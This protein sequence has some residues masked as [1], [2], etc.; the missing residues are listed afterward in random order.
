MGFSNRQG[1]HNPMSQRPPL[2]LI[3]GMHRNGTSLLGSLLPTCGIATPGPLLQETPTILG[4]F[5][6]RWHRL[7]KQL[8]ID[9]GLVAS[10]GRL[11]AASLKRMGVMWS[12]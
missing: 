1:A 5:R 12:T 6:T 8:L 11:P 10:T 4:L 7:C 9:L 2:T 3:V